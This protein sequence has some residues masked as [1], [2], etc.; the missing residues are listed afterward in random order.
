MPYSY[1]FYAPY[2]TGFHKHYTEV[3]GGTGWRGEFSL[4]HDNSLGYRNWLKTLKDRPG[5]VRYSLR[6][7]YTVVSD[8]ARRLALKAAT[9]VYLKE[10]AI[11]TQS[12]PYCRRQNKL[13]NN[14]CPLRVSKGTLV[15]TIVR[16]WNLKGDIW[17]RTEGYVKMWY[18]SIY[19]RTSVKK[20]N[21]PYWN[22]RY[23]L[24]KVDTFLGLRI[25]VWDKDWGRDDRL[26]SCV[27]YLSQG[28]HRITCPAKRGGVEIRYTLTCDKPQKKSTF[29]TG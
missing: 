29:W 3:V 5:I 24:G 27:K 23:Y 7:M 1:Y 13:H 4:T 19:R 2:G 8:W 22:A 9:E 21:Y 18:G 14:C 17:G 10:N 16:A 26:G 15:V 6:P 28:T 25:E 20:S 12:R 11:G